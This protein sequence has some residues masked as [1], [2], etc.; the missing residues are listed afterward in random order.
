MNTVEC[1]AGF[2]GFRAA[3]DGNGIDT[4]WGCEIDRYARKAYEHFWGDVLEGE[5][6]TQVDASSIP[7]HDILTGGF[8]C[9]SFS[10]AGV[11]K[12]QS[13]GRPHGF[14]DK[15]RGT[16][17]FDLCRI[18]DERR[19]PA[20]VFENVKNIRSHN[21]GKTLDVI[22]STLAELDY[23]VGHQV[24]DAANWVPQHRERTFFVGFRDDLEIDPSSVLWQLNTP[25]TRPVDLSDVIESDPDPK[26]TLG[27]GTWAFHIRHL[28]N[29][30]AKGKGFG[31][32]LIEPPFE[33]KTTRTLSHRYHKDGAEIL[34]A[35]PGMN[36]RKLT[37]I[38]CLRL[39]G[40]PEHLENGLYDSGLSDTRLWMG[41][42]NSVA[43]PV[44][45][46]ILRMVR[47]LLEEA[48]YG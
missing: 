13:L 48:G 20:F 37:P 11:P 1:F 18:L 15:T 40:F 44:V 16:L 25:E 17:F 46:E 45:S 43:V 47:L 14:M 28:E 19:P 21:G 29:C 3:A 39:Q 8:P 23:H 9:Q 32:G 36:P 24:I 4:I 2:G 5:D 38:E 22:L 26:Y 35:Q 42:G 7:D 33:G 27:D 10:L 6:I 30:R 12:H 34:I 31:Y 41:F